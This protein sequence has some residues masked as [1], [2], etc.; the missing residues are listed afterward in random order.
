MSLCILY[1]KC[2]LF[3]KKNEEEEEEAETEFKF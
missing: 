3:F 2:A 1:S